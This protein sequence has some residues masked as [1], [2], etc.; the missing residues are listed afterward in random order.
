MSD[1][2]PKKKLV[3][4]WQSLHVVIWV[5]GLYILFRQGSFFPGIL[6]LIAISALYE[7]FVRRYAPGAYVEE[8][9]AEPAPPTGA[10]PQTIDAQFPP[11]APPA[12]PQEHRTD[13]LPLT[14][15]NCGGPVRG[16]EVKWTGSQTANCPFCGTNLP[17]D[18]N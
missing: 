1:N 11:A 6:V 10:P 8:Q 4:P 15:P 14:C 7:A 5:L 16:H 3:G 12:P 13:L 2:V 9:A 18:K 17:M